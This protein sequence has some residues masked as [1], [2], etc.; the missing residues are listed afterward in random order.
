MT[1]SAID[2]VDTT[3]S[4][5]SA[6]PIAPLARVASR[7]AVDG[8]WQVRKVLVAVAALWPDGVPELLTVGERNQAIDDWLKVRGVNHRPC[9]RTVRRA[10]GGQ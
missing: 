10:L 7:R 3:N 5:T 6:S 2:G 8:G 4:S 9:V 1:I